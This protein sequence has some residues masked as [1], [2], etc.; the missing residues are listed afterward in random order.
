[1]T[2]HSIDII[3]KTWRDKINGNSYSSGWLV[4]NWGLT[5]E[6]SYPI[7]FQYGG[8]Q[9]IK[10]I[11]FGMLEELHGITKHPVR[12]W[13]RY[14]CVILNDETIAPLR[15]IWLGRVTKK[16]CKTFTEHK[17]SS[18]DFSVEY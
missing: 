9:S 2:I 15:E 3:S 6:A 8:P 16:E 5:D 10:Q 1:M 4:L 13:H 17:F 14:G 7:S 11:A 12:A 18:Y